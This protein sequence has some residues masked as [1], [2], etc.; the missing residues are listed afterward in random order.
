[1]DKNNHF[2]RIIFNAFVIYEKILRRLYAGMIKL[3]ISS[4]SINYNKLL[5]QS[6]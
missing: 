6:M 2:F 4:E 3:E 1:M 5:I